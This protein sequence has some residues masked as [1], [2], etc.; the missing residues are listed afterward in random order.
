MGTRRIFWL[1]RYLGTPVITS[2]A[3]SPVTHYGRY[4]KIASREDSAEQVTSIL[5]N[6]E[7]NKAIVAQTKAARKLAREQYS[8]E[9]V[10]G[11][12]LS[13]Y[14]KVLASR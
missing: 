9:A 10:V 13:L 11:R 4:G 7:G 6:T 8:E 3:L 2:Q 1:A 14:E 12:T 5:G